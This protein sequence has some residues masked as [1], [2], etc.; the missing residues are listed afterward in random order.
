VRAQFEERRPSA[1]RRRRFTAL[2]ARLRLGTTGQVNL[3]GLFQKE[4]KQPSAARRSAFGAVVELHSGSLHELK[5]QPQWITRLA[6]ALPGV[7]TMRLP[8]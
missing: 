2:A 1:S 7:R 5:F 8:S 3:T 6:D 4:Q